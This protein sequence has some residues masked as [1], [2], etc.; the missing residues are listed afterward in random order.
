VITNCPLTD[1]QSVR[2]GTCSRTVNDMVESR[3][4]ACRYNPTGAQ[5]P[6]PYARSTVQPA[7]SA[8]QRRRCVPLYDLAQALRV[9]ERQITIRNVDIRQDADFV[10]VRPGWRLVPAQ[11]CQIHSA[12]ITTALG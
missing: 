7:M 8:E 6:T 3:Q 5:H 2:H 12:C 9:R 1:C 11:N 4:I 10:D